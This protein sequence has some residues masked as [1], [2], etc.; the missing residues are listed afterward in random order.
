MPR[1]KRHVVFPVE[2]PPVVPLPP[3]LAAPAAVDPP[4]AEYE[5]SAVRDDD[6]DGFR[7]EAAARAAAGWRLVAVHAGS[8]FVPGEGAARV[9]L[10]YWERTPCPPGATP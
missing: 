5:R 4:P 10:L 3:R 6:D 1:S 7:R 2:P 9:A 8:R